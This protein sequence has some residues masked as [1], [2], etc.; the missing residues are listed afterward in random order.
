MLGLTY[1][2]MGWPSTEDTLVGQHPRLAEVQYGK[3][4]SANKLWVHVTI[5]HDLITQ[6][7]LLSYIKDVLL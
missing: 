7:L 6:V 4:S 2:G 3:I 5:A 1:G